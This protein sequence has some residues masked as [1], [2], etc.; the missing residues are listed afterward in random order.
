MKI[1]KAVLRYRKL[2]N[3][4]TRASASYQELGKIAK[5]LHPLCLTVNKVQFF[6][7]ASKGWVSSPPHIVTITEAEFICKMIKR[8]L[9]PPKM[10]GL[11]A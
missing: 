8:S 7:P 10:L 5:I 2:F 1:I 11:K 9:P 3:R 4:L 6:S